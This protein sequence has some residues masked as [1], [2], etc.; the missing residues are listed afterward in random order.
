MLF[1]GGIAAGTEEI[2]LACLGYLSGQLEIDEIGRTILVDEDV[3]RLDVPVDPSMLMK[4]AKG[5]GDLSADCWNLHS[6]ST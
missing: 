1:W 6:F 2:P 5:I 3:L 4:H